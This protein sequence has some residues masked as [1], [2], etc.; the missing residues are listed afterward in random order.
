MV[1]HWQM[2]SLTSAQLVNRLVHTC[3]VDGTALP[4][5]HLWTQKGLLTDR[6]W[7]VAGSKVEFVN[8]SL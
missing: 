2:N 8:P 6:T 7:L 3:S 5:L 4:A 1:Q